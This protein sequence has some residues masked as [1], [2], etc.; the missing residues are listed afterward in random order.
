MKC[1]NCDKKRNQCECVTLFGERANPLKVMATKKPKAKKEILSREILIE[2]LN[3]LDEFASE[4]TR[5]N[6]NGEAEQQEKDYNMLFNF[7]TNV[8]VKV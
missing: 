2:A 5:D 3:R 8:K 4:A 7:L 1:P 6:D